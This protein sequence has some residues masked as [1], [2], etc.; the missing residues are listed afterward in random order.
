VFYWILSLLNP[1]QITDQTVLSGIT[2]LFKIDLIDLLPAITI[3]IFSLLQIDVKLSMITSI[4]V[5]MAIALFHQDYSL[6]K[7]IQFMM[8]GFHLDE[9]TPLQA[10]LLGGGV[11]SMVKVAIVVI[12][13]TAFV[14]IFVGTRT[15][16]QVERV[17]ERVKSRRDCFLS[18][19]LVGI[20]SAAF[21]C[22]QTI[23]IL[24]TQ[25]LVEKKYAQIIDTCD[26]RGEGAAPSRLISQIGFYSDEPEYK[27]NE[28]GNYKLALDL[29]NT[30][31]VIAAL[32]PWNIAALVPAT[33]LNTDAGFIPY[34]VYL[35][36]V[37]LLNLIH[38]RLSTP[39]R[40]NLCN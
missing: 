22:T 31:V 26:S 7:L 19:C 39:P 8:L 34:A 35:Y 12:I 3:L 27:E 15:L 29:E 10:I 20:A 37:P 40:L 4:G 6:L 18:T 24:L 9:A 13:S 21:G 33:I 38:L 28:K 1:V 23:A 14:G 2:Q 32:I 5:A 30:V 16:Q 11:L 17:L 36:L 25:Q